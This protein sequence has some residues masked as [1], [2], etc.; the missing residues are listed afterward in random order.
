ML[1]TGSLTT[2]TINANEQEIQL[3]T[4]IF[5]IWN[6]KNTLEFYSDRSEEVCTEM[7]MII[8]KMYND[9]FIE[10]DNDSLQLEGKWNKLQV[11][12][13]SNINVCETHD[14]N[15]TNINNINTVIIAEFQERIRKYNDSYKIRK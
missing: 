7:S 8:E 15:H 14:L 12:F 11:I 5:N 13:T 6:L 10:Y 2:M 9:N 3:P 4:S 1:Y